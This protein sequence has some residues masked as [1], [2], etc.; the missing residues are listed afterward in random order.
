MAENE[1]YE[2]S[3]EV[4]AEQ[5]YAEE[6][7]EQA[8][9]EEPAAD[10]EAEQEQEQEQ[11]A[12]ADAYEEPAAEEE[13][14]EYVEP[15]AVE[16]PEVKEEEQPQAQAQ[17]EAYNGDK[18]A[19]VDDA[20]KEIYSDNPGFNWFSTKLADSSL[21]TTGL[22]VD[23]VGTGGL[24]EL[25]AQMAKESDNIIFFL[26]RCDTADDQGSSRAKFVY[27]RYKGSKV[28]FMQKAKLTPNLGAFADQF[29]VKHLSK[30][31]DEEMKGWTAEELGKE[32]LRIGGAHK[33][34]RYIFGPDAVYNVPK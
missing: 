7:A 15:A 33:P 16:E 29:Q 27:G 14:A 20:C 11:E 28:K 26:L 1:D 3:N 22:T 19:S 4:E 2:Q 6:P 5:E 34:Q 24:N 12:E 17:A 10:V 21:K 31:A 23:V 13:A 8:E 32:F 25:K 18:P 9:Y 30:D